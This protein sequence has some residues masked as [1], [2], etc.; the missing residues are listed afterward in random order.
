MQRRELNI[1]NDPKLLV[2]ESKHKMKKTIDA[3]QA[4]MSQ[5]RSGRASLGIVE[6][7]KVDV[8]GQSMPLN[9]LATI[10]IPEARQIFIDAWDKA[11]ISCIEKAIQNSGRDLNPTINGLI[12]RI[13]L[14]D[15]TEE[16]RKKLAKITR[17]KLE[18]YKI[19]IRNIRR[20]TNDALKKMKDDISEDVFHTYQNEVQKITDQH[21]AQADK[22]QNDK[23]QE[24]MTI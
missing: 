9:Q 10:T 16:N 2:K 1:M 3:L 11:N 13:N 17:Q 22:I 12:I 4:A 20:D 15:L 21:I 18:D 7:I 19:A 8:Y 6:D 5:I 14:P 23:E 24:I